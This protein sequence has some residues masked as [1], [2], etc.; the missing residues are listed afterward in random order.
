MIKQK[1]SELLQN[2]DS[3]VR[4]VVESVIQDEYSQ[5]DKKKPRGMFESICEIIEEEVQRNET[6]IS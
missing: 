1:I 2:F 3:D 5:L 6:G 4:R